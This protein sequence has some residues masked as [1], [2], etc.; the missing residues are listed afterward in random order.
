MAEG[1][2]L[3]PLGDSPRFFG[4]ERVD[5]FPSPQLLTPGYR[6]LSTCGSMR[7]Y[8]TDAVV[9]NMNGTTAD[10]DGWLRRAATRPSTPPWIRPTALTEE[11]GI[12]A[13]LAS[14]WLSIHKDLAFA[15]RQ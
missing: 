14:I 12:D 13:A 4:P 1:R 7:S 5:M 10:L 6:G 9:C 3:L 8:Y 15:P 11:C 2:A